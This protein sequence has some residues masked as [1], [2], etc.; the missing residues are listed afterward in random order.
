MIEQIH[1]LR[2]AEVIEAVSVLEVLH[3]ILKDGTESGA[4]HATELHQLFS[5][6][7][8]PQINLVQAAETIVIRTG[9]VSRINPSSVQEVFEVSRVCC[10]IA[11]RPKHNMHR[12]SAFSLNSCF[13]GYQSMRAISCDEVYDG[14]RV[15]DILG[16]IIPACIRFKLRI[17][18]HGIQFGASVIER[19]NTSVTTA[20]HVDGR[21]IQRQPDKVI[22][23]RIHHEFVN[24][25][26]SLTSHA[27]EDCTP[28]YSSVNSACGDL[29]RRETSS[30]VVVHTEGDRIEESSN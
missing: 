4:Q 30:S 13:C 6:T 9:T 19:W 28:C 25:I 24:L 27:A 23:Q 15:F 17:A 8:N 21:K 26:T 3:L 14:F 12:S 22:A 7:A 18:S 1:A 2:T 5:K 11:W 20:G 10:C 29:S 16:E